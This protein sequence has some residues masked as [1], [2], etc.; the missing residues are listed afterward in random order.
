[1]ILN[2]TIRLGD[3]EIG[4]SRPVYVVFEAGPTHDGLKTAKMLVD[5]A[6]EAGADAVKFQLLQADRIVSSQEVQFSYTRL[7]DEKTGQTEEITEPLIDILRRREL[8]RAEWTELIHHCRKR[9]IEFFSTAT[10]EDELSFLSSNGVNTVKICSGDVNYHYFLRQA[11]KYR[12]SVQIDTGASTLGEIETAVD[13]L[14][15]AGCDNII[16]NHCPSG[17]PA[18]LDSINLNVISTLKQ[19]FPCPVAFSDHSPGFEMD[20]AAVAMGVHMIE[21]TITLDRTTRSPEHIMSLNPEACKA[22]VQTIRDVEIAKGNSRRQLSKEE[23]TKCMNL[24]RSIFAAMDIKKG[25]RLTQSMI[26]Y[27]RPG[28]GI[29]A[30]M[31]AAVLGRMAKADIPEASKLRFDEFE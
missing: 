9:K 19:M 2:K 8:S 6:A 10:D 14:E 13:I 24:R 3:K 28:D 15:A 26:Q 1:M 17:Y 30:D 31:D 12:W 18:R 11:A 7:V 25:Q 5:I 22:F 27:L 29:P 23:K 16:I 20:I 21:K 4:P